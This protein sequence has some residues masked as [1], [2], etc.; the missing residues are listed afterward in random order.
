MD[1]LYPEKLSELQRRKIQEE[2]DAIRLEEEAA[3]G[4]SKWLDKNLAA[5]G[6]WMIKRGEKLRDRRQFNVTTNISRMKG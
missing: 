1:N 4:Q 2:M 5:L 6:S 3:K